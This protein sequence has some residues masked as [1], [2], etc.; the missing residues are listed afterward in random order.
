MPCWIATL[1]S[2]FGP[3]FWHDPL[4]FQCREISKRCEV[5]SGNFFAEQW[6][7]HPIPIVTGLFFFSVMLFTFDFNFSSSV[8][9]FHFFAALSPLLA[10]FLFQLF[11][12][13]IRCHM[14]SPRDRRATSYVLRYLY[15]NWM[16]RCSVVNPDRRWKKHLDGLL[17]V[18]AVSYLPSD[19]WTEELIAK[20]VLC[21]IIHT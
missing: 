13:I 16:N 8:I 9:T 10:N 6:C 19:W 14:V 5:V 4:C 20:F 17:T 11:S 2:K 15:M 18:M 7:Q 12:F 1:L 3:I 21:A